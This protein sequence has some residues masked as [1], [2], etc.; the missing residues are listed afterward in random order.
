MTHPLHFLINCFTREQ[1][2]EIKDK[3]SGLEKSYGIYGFV[4]TPEVAQC[5]LEHFSHLQ[6]HNR[7][8]EG[9]LEFLKKE[10]VDFLTVF[11]PYIDLNDLFNHERIDAT[12]RMHLRA[13]TER[14][15][16]DV[17]E[18]LF[19]N[20]LDINTL[21]LNGETAL[22]EACRQKNSQLIDFLIFKGINVSHRIGSVTA[23]KPAI[24]SGE[25]QN[26]D[27]LICAGIDLTTGCSKTTPIELAVLN[28]FIPIVDRLVQM[29]VPLTSKLIAICVREGIKT[30][31][32]REDYKLIIRMLRAAGC[33][34]PT[35][36]MMGEYTGSKDVHRL[37]AYMLN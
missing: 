23:L 33:E 19:N 10:R 36:K 30:T 17:I 35:D 3:L 8:E 18:F 1:F 20:G 4:Q 11:L 6:N 34:G 2:E 27:R 29:S 5:F 37:K 25:V 9:F 13:S 28:C 14:G 7:V 24:L 12:A 15:T 32:K 21:F 16:M 26:V 31:E 22:F